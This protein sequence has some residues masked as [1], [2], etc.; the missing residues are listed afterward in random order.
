MNVAWVIHY[1]FFGGPHNRLARA[2]PY[3]VAAGIDCTAVLPDEAGNAAERLKGAGVP[4][5]RTA[6]TRIRQTPD[7]R[8][9]FRFLGEYRRDVR[10]MRG[11]LRLLGAEAL[12][13]GGL[14]NTQAPLAAS[15]EGVPLCWQIVDSRTPPLLRRSMMPLVDRL[16]GSV[17]FGAETLVDL[18][19][20]ARELTSPTFINR[21]GVD[22]ESFRPSPE[23]RAATR[24]ALGIAPSAPVVGTVANLNPQKGIEYFLRAAG[25]ISRAAPEAVFLLVGAC[26]PNHRRY[27]DRLRREARVAGL[28]RDRL[29]VPGARSDIEAVYPAIDVKLV[30]SVPNSEGTT[31]TAM[32]AMA[33]GV[34]VV[35]TNVGGVAEVVLDGVTGFMVPAGDV[36]ALVDR[37]VELLKRPDVYDRFAT[38]GI[39]RIRKDFT[40]ERNASVQIEAIHAATSAADPSPRPS[41]AAKVPRP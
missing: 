9:H 40:I 31:T 35:A 34:P 11:T 12:V 24:K 20:G 5:V 2:Y 27:H 29:I 33:C 7:P 10:R 8:R 18:H 16:A 15:L 19:P 3:L 23:R 36:D 41:A 17:M 30:T 21:P 22:V 25:R 1:P 4:V 13:V 28:D 26:S 38:A 32:E 37:A 14:V 6:M 39:E